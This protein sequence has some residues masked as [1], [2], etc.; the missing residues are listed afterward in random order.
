MA[1]TELLMHMGASHG[2]MYGRT[3]GWND[4]HQG[5]GLTDVPPHLTEQ[6]QVAWVVGWL[7]ALADA[8]RPM[9]SG[10]MRP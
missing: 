3:E 2:S 10:N 5:K 8:A 6:D 7:D 4:F 9:R 1:I